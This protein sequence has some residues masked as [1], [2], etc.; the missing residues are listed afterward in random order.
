MN[1]LDQAK[2]PE[3]ISKIAAAANAAQR[4][5][6]RGEVLLSPFTQES[7]GESWDDYKEK[8]QS[9]IDFGIKTKSGLFTI[10]IV[11]K[12][13]D[14]TKCEFVMMDYVS[15]NLQHVWEAEFDFLKKKKKELI[16]NGKEHG[17]MPLYLKNKCYEF[18]GD[19]FGIFDPLAK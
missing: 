17:S 2:S 5:F 10:F 16:L 11:T 7:L 18:S 14:L 15:N 8:S 1:A 13:D 6:P 4:I 12:E 9:S 19:L 3:L